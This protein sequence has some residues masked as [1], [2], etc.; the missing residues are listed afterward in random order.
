MEKTI[1]YLAFLLIVIHLFILRVS[2]M[3]KRDKSN[4]SPPAEIRQD[5]DDTEEASKTDEKSTSQ[6]IS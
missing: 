5:R 4:D 1:L 6:A 2:I 3:Q